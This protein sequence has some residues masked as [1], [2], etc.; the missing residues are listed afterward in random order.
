MSERLYQPGDFDLLTNTELRARRLRLQRELD[1]I[2]KLLGEAL[3]CDLCDAPAGP[4]C[5]DEDT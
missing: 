5:T 2:N 1:Q 3:W 4:D